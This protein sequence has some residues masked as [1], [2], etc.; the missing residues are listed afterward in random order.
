[1]RIRYLSCLAL[2]IVVAG[3][4]QSG[5]EVAPVS[6]RVTVD[7]QPMENVDV[8]FQPE[9]SRSPSYG[10]TDKDGHYTLG[11]NRNVQGALVGA[12]SVGITISPEVVRKPPHIKNTQLRREVKSGKNEFDF[13]V[14]S[15]GK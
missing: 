5:P 4:G 10:R 15:E 1:M 12:H 3:C 13:D 11:Y 9:D 8:V 14:T 6:G 2:A 7:G